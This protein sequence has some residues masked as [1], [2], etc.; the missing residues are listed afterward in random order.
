MDNV[1]VN[2]ALEVNYVMKSIA[3]NLVHPTDFV[4][5]IWI[6]YVIPDFPVN[7]VK[8]NNATKNAFME[9]VL[10]MPAIVMMVGLAKFVT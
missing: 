2:L 8:L 9:N 10:T 3:M 4:I 5:K 7:S 1:I 6:V